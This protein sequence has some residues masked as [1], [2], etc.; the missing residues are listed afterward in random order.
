M[1][2]HLGGGKKTS[3]GGLKHSNSLILCYDSF[4]AI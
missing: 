3:V 1:F 2:M 4:G